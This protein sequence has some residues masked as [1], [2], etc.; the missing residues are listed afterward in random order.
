MAW[1]PTAH[2]LRHPRRVSPAQAPSVGRR[3]FWSMEKCSGSSGG[4]VTLNRHSHFTASLSPPRTILT[5]AMPCHPAAVCLMC[6]VTIV[7]PF[8]SG[9]EVVQTSSSVSYDI[10]TQAEFR[11]PSYN[12]PQVS[13]DIYTIYTIYSV[14]STLPS[15]PVHKHLRFLIIAP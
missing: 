5:I 7:G 10:F 14:D 13:G 4:V 11:L 15:G 2:H 1:L 8:W 6:P 12:F 9:Y 3:Q